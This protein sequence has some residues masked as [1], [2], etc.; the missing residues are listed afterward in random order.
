VYALICVFV[1]MHKCTYVYMY[2]FRRGQSA[3]PATS[4]SFPILRCPFLTQVLRLSG[5]TFRD[6]FKHAFACGPP[7]PLKL[8]VAKPTKSLNHACADKDRP[9][10][11][12]SGPSGAVHVLK[13]LYSL[14][15]AGTEWPAALLWGTRP[16]GFSTRLRFRREHHTADRVPP[17]GTNKRGT[18]AR[19]RLSAHQHSL[20][21]RHATRVPTPKILVGTLMC[22][23]THTHVHK[24]GTYIWVCVWS[25]LAGSVSFAAAALSIYPPAST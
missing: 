24:T 22:A 9:R 25:A 19:M 12:L 16:S 2:T 7:H 4:I 21:G 1:Y 17:E 23:S 18:F 11:T 13:I 6:L 5:R 10:R 20:W 8:K 15:P 14:E 3:S